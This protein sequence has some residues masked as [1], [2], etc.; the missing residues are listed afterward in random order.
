MN[1]EPARLSLPLDR[2]RLAELH[3][4]DACLLTGPLYTLRDAGHVRLMAE[5]EAAD[6]TLPQFW[7]EL[8]AKA[9]EEIPEGVPGTNPND[10]ARESILECAGRY[11]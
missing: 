6:G 5:L 4:G 8:F 2:A 10:M 7:T 1:G 11:Y 9:G 3:A